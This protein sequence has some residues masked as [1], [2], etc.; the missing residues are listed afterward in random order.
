MCRKVKIYT[1]RYNDCTKPSK[2]KKYSNETSC[3]SNPNAKKEKE[4]IKIF[5]AVLNVKLIGYSCSIITSRFTYYC[6]SFS[7]IKMAKVQEMELNEGM[8]PI[9]W[10]N[11]MNSKRTLNTELLVKSVDSDRP[12]LLTDTDIYQFRYNISVSVSVY[13]Y[14]LEIS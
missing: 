10:N 8:T 11:P 2:K 3:K 7:H 6:G 14:R 1:I 13:W 9:K 5:Q 12:I 4:M